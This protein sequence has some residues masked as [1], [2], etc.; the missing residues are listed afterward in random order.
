MPL[1][2]NYCPRT[3]PHVVAVLTQHPDNALA[4]MAEP[5]PQLASLLK[6]L[7]RPF[8]ISCLIMTS[9][10][11]PNVAS[12]WS[13]QIINTSHPRKILLRPP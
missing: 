12:C 11:P 8:A 4:G 5:L 3:T 2:T 10:A 13:C 6:K 1:Y 9:A 7:I